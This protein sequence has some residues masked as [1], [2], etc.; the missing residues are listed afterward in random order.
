MRSLFALQEAERLSRISLYGV[1]CLLIVAGVLLWQVQRVRAAHARARLAQAAAERANSAKSEFLANMSHEIR[2]PMNGIIGMTELALDTE[3]APEQAEYLGSVKQS[4]YSLL[5]ILNDILD[6]SK[7]EAGKLELVAEDF[8]LRDCIADALQPLGAR[9]GQKGLELVCRIAPELPDSL[10]GDSGR[11]RQ[12]LVNL[13]GNAIKFTEQGE[14]AVYVTSEQAAE[15]EIALKF[16]VCD[17]GI[18]VPPD[19]QRVIFEPF[20]QA[21]GSMTRR[22]GGTGL[23]LAISAKLAGLMQGRIWLESPAPAGKPPARRTPMAAQ[24]PLSI[25]R[26]PSD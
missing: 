25:S 13:V 23:G 2:T 8:C 10:R 19:K 7:I 12:I 1:V 22:F 4:A 5:S 20:E 11:L 15:S 21:D 17:T 24:D 14:V 9:A 26:S 16:S 6:F 18:G 3:L